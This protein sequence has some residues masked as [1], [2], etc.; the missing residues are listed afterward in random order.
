V[1]NGIREIFRHGRLMMRRVSA[2]ASAVALASIVSGCGGQPSAGA[3]GGNG[4][5]GPEL[6]IAGM[7]MT[8]VRPSGVR[9]R[10][11]ADRATYALAG[12]TVTA[13]GVTFALREPAGDVRVTAPAATWNVERQHAAFPEGCDADYP[14]GYSAKVPA[15]GLDLRQRVLTASGPSVFSGPGFKVTG[16]DFV[17]R[18]REGK[19]D[20]KQPKSVIAPD[21][22][23][24]LKRG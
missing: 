18:W 9:Y 1:G 2:F 22:V 19:A 20:L 24:A 17:W 10:L 11:S 23:P 8:E 5:A 12:K 3:N 16:D 6:T 4:G 14:G 21:G 7:E 13:E 15:A